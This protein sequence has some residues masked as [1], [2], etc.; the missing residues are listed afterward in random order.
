MKK[1][2]NKFQGLSLRWDGDFV[3]NMVI[4]IGIVGVWRG[5]WD[6]LDMYLFPKNRILSDLTS[7][8]LGLLLLYLPDGSLHELGGYEPGKEDLSLWGRI[9]RRN[10]K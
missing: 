7:L 4:V 2:K 8:I 9:F 5:L 10:K 6:L 3:R 1:L